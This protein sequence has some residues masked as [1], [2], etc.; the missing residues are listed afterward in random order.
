[1]NVI[2]ENYA[3]L[4]TASQQFYDDIG[5]MKEEAAKSGFDIFSGE[6][7][8][9]NAV[10]GGI[11]NVTQD[12]AEEMNGRMTQIQSHTF[13]INEN[14]KLMV[15]MQT[16]QLAILQ[17]IHS[18]TGQLHAIRADIASVKATVADIQ[19]RGLKLKE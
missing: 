9:R 12:T 13:S 1:M 3:D 8:Q 19:I 6:A 18:D 10:S 17:G 15:N 5:Y 16:T 4:T 7:A 11:A 2:K 14:M